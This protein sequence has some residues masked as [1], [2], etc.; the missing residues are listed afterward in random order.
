MK[1]QPTQTTAACW[2]RSYTR[3]RGAKPLCKTAPASSFMLCPSRRACPRARRA[4]CVAWVRLVEN[5]GRGNEEQPAQ[6]DS[7]TRHRNKTRSPS[8]GGIASGQPLTSLPLFFPFP[9]VYPARS[10]EQRWSPEV[11]CYCYGSAMG[12]ADLHLGAVHLPGT[13]LPVRMAFM[14]RQGTRPNVSSFIR[15]LSSSTERAPGCR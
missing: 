1:K 4:L 13:R 9:R 5:N 8:Q 6:P 12:D 7:S 15:V 14:M 10:G 3:V 11:Q 2:R